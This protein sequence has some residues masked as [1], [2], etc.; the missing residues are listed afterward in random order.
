MAALQPFYPVAIDTIAIKNPMQ[1]KKCFKT[2]DC[3]AK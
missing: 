2:V 3:T 1:P